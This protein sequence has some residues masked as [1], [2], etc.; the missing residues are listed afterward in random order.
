MKAN[1]PKHEP[2]PLCGQLGAG[3]SVEFLPTVRFKETRLPRWARNSDRFVLSEICGDSLT[4]VDIRDGDLALIYLTIDVKPGDL[5]AVLTPAGLLVKF[6]SFH[7]DQVR[8]QS[9][10]PNYPPLDYNP[11]D[12]QIQGKV[13]R[14]ERPA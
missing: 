5:V 11:E 12:V 1:D 4:G 14:T 6:L 10:N 9:A 2:I 8:L 3:A 13:I 7:G